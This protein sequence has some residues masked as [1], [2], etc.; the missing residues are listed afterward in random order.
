MTVSYATALLSAVVCVP[1]LLWWMRDCAP[2]LR[3]AAVLVVVSL[4]AVFLLPPS[5]HLDLL[6][7]VAHHWPALDALAASP[8]TS[9]LVHLLAFGAGGL[10]LGRVARGPERRPTLVL[11]VA[12]GIGIEALQASVPGHSVRV[13]DALVNAL[14]AAAGFSAAGRWRRRRS[15]RR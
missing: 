10:A 4:L 8:A 13:A 12:A 6:R 1:A 11:L 7:A 3:A 14:G 15:P 9:W 5:I 2:A